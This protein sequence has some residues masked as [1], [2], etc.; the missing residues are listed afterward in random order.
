MD[1][2]ALY[3]ATMRLH[4]HECASRVAP[5]GLVRTARR[6]SIRWIDIDHTDV[7]LAADLA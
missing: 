7:I 2:D 6:E 4:S 3:C 1:T 5:C